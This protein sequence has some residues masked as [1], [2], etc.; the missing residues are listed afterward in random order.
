MFNVTPPDGKK[1]I[2]V[3]VVDDSAF[4]RYTI[5][6]RLAQSPEILVVGTA[7]DG[8]EALELIPSL[9]PDVVTLDVEMPRLDGLSTLREIMADHP[10]PVVMLSS[11]TS[12]GAV[13]T[14]QALTLGAVDFIAKPSNKANI[15]AVME[16]VVGKIIR[17]ARAKVWMV[18]RNRKFEPAPLPKG[19]KTTR[20]LT[21]QDRILVIG[22]STGGPRALSTLVP[23][24][25]GN[26]PAAVLIIQHMPVGFTRS[27]AERLDSLSQLK[28]KEAEPGDRLEV[29]RALVA[30][31]G[32]HMILDANG[33]ISLNQNPPVHAVRPA[34]DVTMTSVVQKYGRATVGVILTGMGNDGTTGCTLIHSAGGKV[35]SEAESSCVVYGM[36]RSVYEAGVVDVVAPLTDVAAAI[37]RIING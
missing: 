26:L 25:P 30:P 2:K 23:A 8:Q 20:K 17:A 3:L 33:E 6:Q 1:P 15:G 12:Q 27:L 4:M 31:G 19:G 11:L 16:E 10:R 37:E 5:T 22:S 34:I 24:I 28:V 14:V 35:I 13:E 36:P 29:G 9:N 7:R 21:A 18:P 32:F